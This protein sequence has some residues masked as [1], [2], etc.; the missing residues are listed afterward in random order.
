MWRCK[1]LIDCWKGGKIFG[2]VYA[3]RPRLS[4]YS[5]GLSEPRE[6]HARPAG[7]RTFVPLIFPLGEAFQFDWSED[8]PVIEQGVLPTGLFAANP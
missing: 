1:T 2:L 3:A 4:L 8:W 5:S 6:E 7:R